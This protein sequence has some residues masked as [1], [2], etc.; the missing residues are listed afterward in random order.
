MISVAVVCIVQLK[1]KAMG[2]IKTMSCSTEL[3]TWQELFVTWRNALC[4][5]E[6]VFLIP[7]LCICRLALD[8]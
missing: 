6:G 3:S 2:A 5:N 7:E 1:H 8:N 4:R